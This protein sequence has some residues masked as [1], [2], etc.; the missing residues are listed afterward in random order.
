MPLELD[1][2]C[3]KRKNNDQLSVVSAQLCFSQM[4]FSNFALCFHS[5]RE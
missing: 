4:V 3:H 1:Y 5:G 2:W